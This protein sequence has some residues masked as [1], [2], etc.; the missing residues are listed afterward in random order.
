MEQKRS[1]GNNP[2]R[3]TIAKLWLAAG[4]RCQ[5]EGC[6]ANLFRDDLTW[7]EF[8][9][10]NVAHIIA[11]SPN[12]PRGSEQSLQ[13]S[14][15][16]DNLMLLCPKHHKEID[17]FVDDYP[18]TKLKEMKQLQE[19]KVRQLLEGMNYPDV[20]ILILES[21]IKGTFEIYA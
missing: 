13:L 2:T 6:N 21:P 9:G 3:E 14:D 15:K 17:T 19:Q 16:L 8:N 7:K 4:G 10:A 12:G 5:F 20:E 11:S 18:V 1:R